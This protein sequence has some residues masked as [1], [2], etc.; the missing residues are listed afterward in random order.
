MHPGTPVTQPLASPR[1]LSLGSQYVGVTLTAGK[2]FNGKF[3]AAGKTSIC[4]DP[5]LKE[6][7]DSQ[8][9][10]SSF[11]HFL[12]PTGKRD[13]GQLVGCAVCSV[14]LREQGSVFPAWGSTSC[15]SG[16]AML[17]DGEWSVS[18][19]D[20]TS[21]RSSETPPDSRGCSRRPQAWHQRAPFAPVDRYRGFRMGCKEPAV[22]AHVD[23][24]ARLWGVKC[25]YCRR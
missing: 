5:S 2:K 6:H 22:H 23:R 20:G 18:W 12:Y 3:Y 8:D 10:S 19:R 24:H 13:E 4:A 25:R 17:Y 16:S 9:S 7:P 14:P 21:S 11:N 1:H 15:P